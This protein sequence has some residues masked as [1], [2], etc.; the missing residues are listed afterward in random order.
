[1][2]LYRISELERQVEALIGLLSEELKQQY[3]QGYANAHADQRRTGTENLRS[4][5]Q[6]GEV[7]HI[8]GKRND[9]PT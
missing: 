8:R 5:A 3:Y 4:F 6:Q 9:F 7:V 1:M 2:G